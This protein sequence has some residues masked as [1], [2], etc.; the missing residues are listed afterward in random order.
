MAHIGQELAFSPRGDL[1]G[2]QCCDQLEFRLFEGADVEN[3]RYEAPYHMVRPQVWDIPGQHAILNGTRVLLAEDDPTNQM[4]AIGLLEAVGIQVDIAADGA[5]AVEMALGKDYEIILMDMQMPVMDGI[6]ATKLIR[7]QDRLAELPVI[8]MT[9]NAMKS[10]QEACLAAGMNDFI[11]KPFDPEQLYTV[12]RKWVT[13]GGDAELFGGLADAETGEAKLPGAIEGLDLRAGLRRMAGMEALYVKSLLSF[14]EQQQDMPARLRQA[15]ADDD[16]ARAT[17]EAHTL[18]GASGIIEAGAVRVLAAELEA[19]LA[20]GD[21]ER[22]QEHLMQVEAKLVPLLGAIETALSGDSEDNVSGDISARL[23]QLKWETANEC[24]HPLIDSQHRELFELGT[25]ILGAM[26][27]HRPLEELRL[28]VDGLAGRI[29]QHFKSEEG[30][31]F[32]AGFPG[33]PQHSV[34][35]QELTHRT[36]ELVGQFR[37]GSVSIEELFDFLADSV[38]RHFLEEDR[39]YHPYLA[40]HPSLPKTVLAEEA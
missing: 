23:V 27:S 33:A 25:T 12:I 11:G 38:F 8:A 15:L 24:G 1:G 18:K 14:V 35:H 30:I 20:E 9:A 4:V 40:V 39:S 7:E 22:G 29:I 32:A 6:T 28:M 13:G 19:A 10:H 5:R 26:Q 16:L 2:L 17:R 34:L 36:V 37:T 31:T 3:L 21:L